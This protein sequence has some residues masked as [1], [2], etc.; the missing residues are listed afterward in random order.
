VNQTG[1]PEP[2][3]FT[4]GSTFLW[5]WPFDSLDKWRV[6]RRFVCSVC[7][8]SL[9][10][11]CVFLALRSRVLVVLDQSNASEALGWSI[12]SIDLGLGPLFRCSF[13]VSCFL[14][15]WHCV[16]IFTPL[17]C[18]KILVKIPKNISMCSWQFSWYFLR[19]CYMLG[20]DGKYVRYFLLIVHLFVKIYEVLTYSWP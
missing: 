7:L 10:M 18:L 16:L 19:H 13:I 9:T 5:S 2:V 6:R 11:V 20:P 4:L 17:P 12:S 14:L 8:L 15:F 1:S 3:W